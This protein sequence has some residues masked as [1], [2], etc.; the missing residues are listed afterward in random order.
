MWPSI[1][2]VIGFIVVLGVMGILFLM[3]LIEVAI[4]GIL[5][6][7]LFLRMY[8]EITKY[9]RGEDYLISG[10]AA[11]LILAIT[12]NFLPL[13]WLTTGILLMFVIAQLYRS[14]RK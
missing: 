3:P 10:V 4:N 14:L 8:T 13:W 5:L 12:K 11:A 7:F 9:K 2:L 6:Y 1:L